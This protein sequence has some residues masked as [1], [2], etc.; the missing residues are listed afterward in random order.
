MPIRDIALAYLQCLFYMSSPYCIVATYID[1]TNPDMA[2][3]F[4]QEFAYGQT[5]AEFKAFLKENYMYD[6][7]AAKASGMTD[8]QAWDNLWSHVQ[9]HYNEI[10]GN[11]SQN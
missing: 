7:G 8:R 9:V 4:L 2:N 6:W 3:M 5:G 10:M 11:Y 1:I